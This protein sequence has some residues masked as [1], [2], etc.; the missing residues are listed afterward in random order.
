VTCSAECRDAM[1]EQFLGHGEPCAQLGLTYVACL[2]AVTCDALTASGDPPCVPDYA[3]C[4]PTAQPPSAGIVCPGG[5]GA[6]VGGGTG[7]TPGTLVCE[8]QRD[9]CSDGHAYRVSCTYLGPAQQVS[10]SCYLDGLPQTSF[11]WT[12]GG[13]YCPLV[14]DVN[15]GCGWQL[16]AI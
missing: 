12:A 4:E 11:L 7:I 5:S 9:G 13:S 8:L 10:C 14:Q 6:A 2:S 1:S 15:N 3:A 16:A